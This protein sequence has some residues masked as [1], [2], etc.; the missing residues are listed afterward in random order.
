MRLGGLISPGGSQQHPATICPPVGEYIFSLPIRGYLPFYFI[1]AKWCP[2]NILAHHDVKH[3]TLHNCVFEATWKSLF[4]LISCIWCYSETAE[5]YVKDCVKKQ[6]KVCVCSWCGL[7]L[8]FNI[9]LN[10]ERKKKYHDAHITLLTG[11]MLCLFWHLR[12]QIT[13]IQSLHFV[14]V[15]ELVIRW[16]GFQFPERKT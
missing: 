3:K 2:K 10:T 6:I 7:R 11:S 9:L 5:H 12:Q 15:P 13:Q 1:R 4:F 16:Q 14:L 8:E